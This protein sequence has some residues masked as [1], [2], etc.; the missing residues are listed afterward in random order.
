MENTKKNFLFYLLFIIQNNIK[1]KNNDLKI[2]I[3]KII[4]F[5]YILIKNGIKI[6]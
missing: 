3:N 6:I 4:L 1:K 2:N 5:K